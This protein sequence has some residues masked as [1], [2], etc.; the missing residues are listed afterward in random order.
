MFLGCF[1]CFT[2]KKKENDEQKKENDEQKKENDEQTK[3][4]RNIMRYGII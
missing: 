3:I 2:N 1:F 4:I